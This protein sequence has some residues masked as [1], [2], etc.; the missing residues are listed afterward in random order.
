MRSVGRTTADQEERQLTVLTFL[1]FQDIQKI[2]Y[3][4]L[5][6]HIFEILD[7]NSPLE[8]FCSKLALA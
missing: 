6:L 2:Y 7:Y 8:I 1:K 4:P 3:V 5:I